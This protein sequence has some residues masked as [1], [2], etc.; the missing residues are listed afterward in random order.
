MP[1]IKKA[2]VFFKNYARATCTSSPLFYR[3]SRFWEAVRECRADRGGM[4]KL[5]I[6]RAEEGVKKEVNEA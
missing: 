5:L 2:P 3:A 4:S 6:M 1:G